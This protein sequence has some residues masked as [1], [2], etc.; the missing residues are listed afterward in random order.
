MYR[1][2]IESSFDAAHKIEGYKG[3]CS[4]LHGHSY[5][6]EVF[7]A[8]K[9]LDKIGL[10]VDFKDLKDKLNRIIEKLDHNY[11]ND[12]KEIGSPSAE[13]ISKYIFNKLKFPKNIKLEKVRV[14]ESHKSYAEYFE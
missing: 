6:V 9:K 12:I 8:G 2:K 13:N 3:K 4:R 11:L 14:W 1:L 10:L 5:K 7:V